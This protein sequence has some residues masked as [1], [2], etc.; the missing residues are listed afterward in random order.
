MK[1]ATSESLL[2]DLNVLLA[3]VWPN[4]QF[5]ESTIKRMNASARPLGD[6]CSHASRVHTPVF[7]SS[8]CSD[9]NEFR[10][11]G[12]RLTAMTKDSLD[13]YIESLPSPAG[14]GAFDRILGHKQVTDVYL[15]R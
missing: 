15:L 13:F 9:G 2:L 14:N 12:S 3:L 11:G 10:G 5:H 6:M 8:R 7:G 1:K 4:H